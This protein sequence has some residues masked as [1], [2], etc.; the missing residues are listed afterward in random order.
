[1]HI[2]HEDFEKVTAIL[3]FHTSVVFVASVCDSGYSSVEANSCY[4]AI[5]F[6]ACVS[7]DYSSVKANSC[8][9]V[10]FFRSWFLALKFLQPGMTSMK[11]CKLC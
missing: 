2:N 9:F 6:M 1:M 5:V 3:L 4:F 8:Y 7:S 10:F 11:N